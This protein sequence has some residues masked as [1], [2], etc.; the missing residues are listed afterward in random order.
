MLS[1]N[2]TYMLMAVQGCS[3]QEGVGS[4]L[5]GGAG[6]LAGRNGCGGRP[7]AGGSGGASYSWTGM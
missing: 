5:R 4:R 2:D 1:R 7:G 6:G 3:P